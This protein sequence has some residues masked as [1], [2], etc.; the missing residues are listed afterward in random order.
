MVFHWGPGAQAIC[1]RHA[2][3]SR[4]PVPAFTSPNFSTPKA[5]QA[6]FA[7]RAAFGDG[8]AAALGGQLSVGSVCG[9]AVGYGTKRVGQLLM[10][11]LGCEIVAIQLMARKGW[12]TVHWNQVTKDISPHVEKEGLDRI[13]ETVKFKLPFGISVRC[14]R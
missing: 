6:S 14:S 3:V 1:S 11:A 10:V 7:R 4:R 13:I 9:F 2:V 5:L 8:A 12:L